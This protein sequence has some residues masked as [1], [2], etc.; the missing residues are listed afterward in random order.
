MLFG[1]GLEFNNY[2]Q[3]SEGGSQSRG[4]LE[5]GLRD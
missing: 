1:L 2:S 4:M 3:A 5:T